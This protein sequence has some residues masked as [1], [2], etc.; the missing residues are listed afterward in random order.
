VNEDPMA[1]LKAVQ[2]PAVMGATSARDEPV[3]ARVVPASAAPYAEADVEVAAVPGSPGSLRAPPSR[4]GLVRIEQ[5][6]SRD[7]LG[8]AVLEVAEEEHIDGD[9]ELR[10]VLDDAL[11][12]R[13][14][15]G[16]DDD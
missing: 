5:P 9:L 15:L 13:V 12:A 14:E 10:Q 6:R 7:V 2:R 8:L 11:G 16:G 1:G 4:L 3:L